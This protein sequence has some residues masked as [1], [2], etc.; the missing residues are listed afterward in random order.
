[1]NFNL[2]SLNDFLTAGES[3][4]PKTNETL[5]ELLAVEA[6]RPPEPKLDPNP[7]APPGYFWAPDY[8]EPHIKHLRQKNDSRP[9]LK[10]PRC[11]ND[12]ER[13]QPIQKLVRARADIKK[14]GKGALVFRDSNNDWFPG[15]VERLRQYLVDFNC[16]DDSLEARTATY[17][18]LASKYSHQIETI[19]L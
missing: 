11:K 8:Y 3:E 13:L 18:F 6:Q 1:M 19:T 12:N 15:D 10:M 17:D 4:E 9:E 7:P 2:K 5:T 14:D 16:I